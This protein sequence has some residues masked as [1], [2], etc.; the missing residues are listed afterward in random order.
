MECVIVQEASP[1]LSALPRLPV[2]RGPVLL[3]EGQD[4]TAAPIARLPAEVS[5]VQSV[6][7]FEEALAWPELKL[8]VV[9]ADN[10]SPGVEAALALARRRRPELHFVALADPIPCGASVASAA[11][12]HAGAGT[13][14]QRR[15]GDCHDREAV[16]ARLLQ[17]IASPAPPAQRPLAEPAGSHQA[18]AARLLSIQEEERRR[19]AGEL[20]DEIGQALTL[21]KLHLE[22][23]RRMVQGPAGEPLSAGLATVDGVL[24]QVRGL[25]LDLRPPQLDQLG[26]VATL[27]GFVEGRAQAGGLV[28]RV[29]APD[30]P[31]RL[32]P[33]LET[34]CYRIAQEAITNVLRHAGARHL[35]V[36]LEAWDDLLSLRIEDDGCGFDVVAAREQSLAGGHAG[37]FGMEERALLSGGALEVDSMPGGGT[38]IKAVLPLR[39][40]PEA[41]P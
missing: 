19:M 28:A 39:W 10:T 17:A 24:Q 36:I 26:L 33:E 31:A 6:L 13:T 15:D 20:H 25:C 11:L 30:I 23:A 18:G 37:L 29:V 21:I 2:R 4:A 1:V 9:L 41:G 34:T 22:A 16:L 32:A 38:R 40:R 7:E 27:R 35:A 14:S 8:I 5:H 12:V 3:L